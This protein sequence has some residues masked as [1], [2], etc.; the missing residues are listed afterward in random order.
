M[1][2][3]K[4]IYRPEYVKQHTQF[5]ST[6]TTLSEMSR[7]EFEAAGYD[8]VKQRIFPD[9]NSRPIDE[10]TEATML[11]SKAIARQDTSG[12][13]QA[14]RGADNS[15]TCRIGVPFPDPYDFQEDGPK[16]KKGWM[17]NCYVNYKVDD[18]WVPLLERAMWKSS[19][20]YNPKA[21]PGEWLAIA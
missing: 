21:D 11:H 5:Y 4:Q 18:Y 2:A 10:S 3:E 15:R 20:S 17:Y 19:P 9:P 12:W 13:L 14:C 6:V 16:D 8:W 1:P 7:R